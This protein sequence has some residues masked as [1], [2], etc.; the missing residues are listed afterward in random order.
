MMWYTVSIHV[1]VTVQ[2]PHVK[3]ITGKNARQTYLYV[4]LLIYQYQQLNIKPLEYIS[5]IPLLKYFHVCSEIRLKDK[6][7]FMSFCCELYSHML[8]QQNTFQRIVILI[9]VNISLKQANAFLMFFFNIFTQG[10]QLKLTLF[11][12][13]IIIIIVLQFSESFSD[14]SALEIKHDSVMDL[15]RTPVLVELIHSL[16]KFA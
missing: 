9:T 13:I 16:Q 8:G 10:K 14:E 1:L 2:P 3:L 4:Y 12:F 5:C 6:T 7:T 15:S 11:I